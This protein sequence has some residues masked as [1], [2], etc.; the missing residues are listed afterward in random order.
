[1]GCTANGVGMDSTVH[2][3]GKI[4]IKRAQRPD[5]GRTRVDIGLAAKAGIDRHDEDKVDEFP[6]IFKA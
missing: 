6:D 3:D 4:R 5:F 1:M 2:F